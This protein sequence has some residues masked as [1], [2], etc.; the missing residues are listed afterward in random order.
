M[1]RLAFFLA[2]TLPSP[3]FLIFGEKQS[4][5]NLK[6]LNKTEESIIDSTQYCFFLTQE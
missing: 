4:A 1:T 6:V 5:S 2:T 3:F